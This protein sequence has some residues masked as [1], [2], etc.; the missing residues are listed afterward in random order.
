MSTHFLVQQIKKAGS[1]FFV[2]VSIAIGMI[3][4]IL[5]TSS[6]ALAGYAYTNIPTTASNEIKT[7][8]NQNIYPNSVAFTPSGGYAILYGTNNYY[9]SNIPQQALNVLSS[10]HKQGSIINSIAFTP[11]GEW[12]II[13]NN[14]GI[15]W[16]TNLPQDVKDELVKI[17]QQHL[18]INNVAFTPNG[19]WV[20]IA[21]DGYNAFWSSNLPP[22]VINQIT[23]IFNTPYQSPIES[24]IFAP[25]GGWIIINNAGS[26]FYSSN[27]PSELYQIMNKE[28]QLSNHPL[29]VA[30]TPTNGWVLIYAL[31][32][33]IPQK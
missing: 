18:N 30:F 8:N 26:T 20:I 2:G 19:A 7:L 3:T 12:V 9:T 11:K 31:I 21:N 1:S 14:N 28:L 15:Y 4:P 33:Y 16:S 29:D 5:L 24:V 27:I 25:N 6:R 13:Y 17:N 10:L 22:L 23:T 32:Q